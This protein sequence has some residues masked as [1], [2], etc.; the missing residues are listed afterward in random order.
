MN[1]EET[2]EQ[3]EQQFY[4]S[5]GKFLSDFAA[6]IKAEVSEELRGA[7]TR[8]KSHD[9][10]W[11]GFHAERPDLK[12]HAGEVREILGR[13]EEAWGKENIS[14]GESYERLAREVDE[15]LVVR[16][17]RKRAGSMNVIDGDGNAHS[18]G[19]QAHVTVKGRDMFVTKDGSLQPTMGQVIRDRQAKFQ[20]PRAPKKEDK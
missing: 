5:P 17:A 4:E 14:V 1:A 12:P 18:M 11:S 13:H 20:N 19:G 7:Y 2:L 10:Y 8:Q 16:D 9:E 3:M 15:A 6:K